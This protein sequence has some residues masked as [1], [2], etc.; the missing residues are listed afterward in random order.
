MRKKFIN[1][2][3][4]LLI[5][6]IGLG[7]TH[8]S[9][10]ENP[11]FETVRYSTAANSGARNILNFTTQDYN[12]VNAYNFPILDIGFEDVLKSE[13]KAQ[14]LAYAYNSE[15][16]Y[17]ELEDLHSYKCIDE[18][19]KKALV[20]AR[21]TYLDN[22]KG[23]SIFDQTSLQRRKN[24][25]RRLLDIIKSHQDCSPNFK[26]IF[27][28]VFCNEIKSWIDNKYIRKFHLKFQINSFGLLECDI[29]LDGKYI[30]M[31]TI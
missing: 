22:Q 30:Y 28:D 25:S 9:A 6:S 24:I 1:L 26:K 11:A 17:D 19:L 16:D 15:D 23:L 31:F 5:T 14:K 4:L 2:F 20:P 18:K 12:F 27:V 10:I 7:S 3:G 29:K 21:E 13:N 8:A